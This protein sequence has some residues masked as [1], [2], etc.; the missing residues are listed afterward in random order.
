[1]ILYS[2]CCLFLCL[3][4]RQW[5]DQPA[6]PLYSSSSDVLYESVLS[7]VHSLLFSAF[8]AYGLIFSSL[9]FPRLLV[10]HCTVSGDMT[11]KMFRYIFLYQRACFP[12]TPQM[13]GKTS[14]HSVSGSTSPIRIFFLT[15]CR[16]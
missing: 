10:S 15:P 11:H 16:S 2:L 4:R 9:S 14:I 6:S 13:H 3:Y 1:M 8:L 7:E 5:E 12:Q